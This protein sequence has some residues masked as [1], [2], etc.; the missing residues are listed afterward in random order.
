MNNK[1][2]N[3]YLHLV[4]DEK[5]IPSAM[6]LFGVVESIDNTYLIISNNDKPFKFIKITENIINCSLN[7]YKY[8]KTI[9]NVNNYSAVIVHYLNSWKIDFLNKIS[10]EGPIVWIAWGGDYYSLLPTL[11]HLL[12]DI[13]TK[14]IF[15]RLNRNK[16]ASLNLKK[17]VVQNKFYRQIKEYWNLFQLRGVLSKITHIAP[18][19]SQEKPIFKKIFKSEKIFLHFN[20][21]IAAG[22]ISTHLAHRKKE[23]RI[24]IGNSGHFSNNHQEIIDILS[25]KY[26]KDYKY[27]FPL[28]YGNELYINYI[29]QVGKEKLDQNFTP[30]FDYMSNSEYFKMLSSCKTGIFNSK[31]QQAGGNIIMLLWSGAKVFLRRE[32]SFYQFFKSKGIE[33]FLVDNINKDSQNSIYLELSKDMQL[34]NKK[35]IEAYFNMDNLK[36]I[37]IGFVQKLKT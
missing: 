12:Y 5:F 8:D 27:I 28:S 6:K 37:T 7:D 23:K 3:K 18:V 2:R 36:K 11:N 30:L 9:N 34:K 35:L 14:N 1:Y 26:R 15:K 22:T 19:I 21:G 13:K 31:R 29:S 25:L 20:Y 17:F 10:F 4:D 16:N 32:N 24:I 33:I